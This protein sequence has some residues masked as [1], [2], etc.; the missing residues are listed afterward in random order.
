[1]S[2]GGL[3]LPPGGPPPGAEF[4]PPLSTAASIARR[5]LARLSDRRIGFHPWNPSRLLS[6]LVFFRTVPDLGQRSGP[7]AGPTLC[8][9]GRLGPRAP[10]SAWG[11]RKARGRSFEEAPAGRLLEGGVRRE[12]L[13]LP[14]VARRQAPN[15]AHRSVLLRLLPNGTSLDFLTAASAST[16]GPVQG[17]Q[18]TELSPPPT[19]F[20]STAKRHFARPSDPR[21]GFHFHP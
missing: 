6:Q 1:M 15:F 4:C 9:H 7:C 13:G 5:H 3:G 18:G 20:A 2:G 11:V 8:P 16:R 17:S 21:V 12:G 14:R 19:T 10:A